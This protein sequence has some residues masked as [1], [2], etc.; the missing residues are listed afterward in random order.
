MRTLTKDQGLLYMQDLQVA[1]YHEAG[2]KII[3]ERF[4]GAGD[5]MVWENSN[6]GNEEVFW[7][8]C[9]RPRTCPEIMHALMKKNGVILPDLPTNWRLLYGVA[10]LVAQDILCCS[11]NDIGIIVE[12]IYSRIEDGGVST[13]DLNSMNITN[14]DDFELDQEGV[15]QAWQYLREDWARVKRE[16]EYVIEEALEVVENS[17]PN[18]NGTLFSASS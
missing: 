7:L 18:D 4:G 10:G 5:A 8:G 2:H 9:F 16:A 13:S 14:I 12:N 1:A 3:Y 11:T 15:K 17:R 6:G